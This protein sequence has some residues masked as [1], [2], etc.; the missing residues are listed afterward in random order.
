MFASK[1]I[2]IPDGYDIDNRLVVDRDEHLIQIIKWCNNLL[3][4]S[5]HV[6]FL[7]GCSGSGKTMLI[8]GA[9]KI[10]EKKSEYLS[11]HGIN[12]LVYDCEIPIILII[13]DPEIRLR[14]N[15]LT[16]LKKKVQ[17]NAASISAYGFGI[18]TSSM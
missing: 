12:S 3:E 1:K 15:A 8:N 7:T 5:G 4:S 10:L 11:H 18:S 6:L 16:I 13:C 2:I 17:L 14:N 9:K